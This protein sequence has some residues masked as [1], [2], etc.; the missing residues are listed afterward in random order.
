MI[1]EV[2][3]DEFNEMCDDFMLD[4]Y[5]VSFCLILKKV[6]FKGKYFFVMYDIFL[7]ELVLLNIGF[8]NF[9]LLEVR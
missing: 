1:E 3:D 8:K 4:G 5:E 6:L 7:F 2:D 9:Y